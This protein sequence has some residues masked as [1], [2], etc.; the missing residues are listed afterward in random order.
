MVF[1]QHTKWKSI[2]ATRRD[3]CSSAVTSWKQHIYSKDE[4]NGQ[5]ENLTDTILGVELGVM[6][7]LKSYDVIS[8]L[9]IFTLNIIYRNIPDS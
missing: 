6:M 4:F 7:T 1:S 5:M 3:V 2:L 8:H 9:F